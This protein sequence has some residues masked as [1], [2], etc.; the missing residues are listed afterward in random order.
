MDPQKTY[1]YLALSRKKI[2][3]WS[4]M[5]SPE[6]YM[7]VFP[8]GLGTL[9][10]TLT[11]IMICEEFYVKRMRG[12]TVPPYAEWPIQD[13]KPPRFEILEKEWKRIET[14]TR[15]LIAE[16]DRA[17]EWGKTMTY[18]AQGDDGKR[19]EISATKGDIFTQLVLH[20]IHHRAQAMN[21]LRQ[22]GVKLEDIDYN[23][24]MYTRRELL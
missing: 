4:R 10:R 24:M 6:Q 9:A 7:Q 3:D 19:T 17:G 20:E 22:L 1:N 12:E 21:I 2:L 5:L 11:H 14:R 13:E 18:V 15:E 16:V 23:A 8:I